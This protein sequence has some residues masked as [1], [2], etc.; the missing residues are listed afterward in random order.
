[1]K[2]PYDVLGISPDATDDEIKKAYRKLSRMY[3]PD[4]NINNP[5]KEQAEDKFKEVQEAYDNI[6]NKKDTGFGE[7]SYGGFSYSGFTGRTGGAG[8][9]DEGSSSHYVAA[10]N[11]IR[12]GMYREAKRVLDEMV[13]K[14]GKWYY[15]SAIA[16]AGLG[17]NATALEHVKTACELEPDN[18]EYRQLYNRLM[19]NSN[20][21]SGMGNVYSSPIN[22]GDG[23]CMKLCLANLFCNLCCC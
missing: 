16:S 20:W 7:N 21:Y 12:N 15:L 22:V 17:N 8:G 1:M 11:F 2:N 4:A 6:M 9:Y 18:M 3:H 19:G 5:N 23:M 14:D 10:A 13:L